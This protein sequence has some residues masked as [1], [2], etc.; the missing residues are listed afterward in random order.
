M[1]YQAFDPST[2]DF[3]SPRVPVLPRPG[4]HSWR[5]RQQTAARNFI[6]SGAVRWYTRG[7]YALTEAFRLCSVGPG[8]TVLAPAYHC[9]SMLDP[10][11][12]LGAKLILYPLTATLAPDL[13]AL[14]RMLKQHEYPPAALLLT[15]FFGFVQPLDMIE[16]IC[17]EY[18][19]ALV[20]DCS[21]CMVPGPGPWSAGH[22]GRYAV[23]SPYKFFPTEDGGCLWANHGA[24]LPSSQ[25][26]SPGLVRELKA[27]ARVLQRAIAPMPA[28]ADTV[29]MHAN[30]ATTPSNPVVADT[31]S[32]QA[33]LSG[34]YDVRAEQMRP[35]AVSRWMMGHTD[36]ERLVM[37]RRKNFLTLVAAVAD[38]KH[39]KALLP[40]LQPDTVPYMFPLLIDRP[41][42]HF[43]AL[44]RL[45][46]PVWRWD[47]MAIS[48]CTTA[49]TYRTHLL[50][51]PC[52]Q[53]LTD[54]QMDW[55]ARALAHGLSD[56]I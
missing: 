37:R 11:I 16:E 39:C 31:V 25:P 24:T 49:T 54:D 46:L 44:K 17:Q 29:S 32:N 48:A 50:H 30:T 33:G 51:L 36:M 26:E 42:P 18:G 40:D 13:V 27:L 47:D 53:E 5:L 38:L 10:A 35:L 3:P 43:F 19:I 2:Y 8:T 15:H 52:H 1:E 45:G 21:H 41:Y 56:T 20:E 22:R 14:R 34:L 7:R 9:R 12:R 55:M 23:A 28:P 4:R 6:S